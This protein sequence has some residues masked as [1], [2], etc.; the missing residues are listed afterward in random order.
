V[1]VRVHARFPFLCCGFGIIGSA[2]RRGLAVT[3]AANLAV[4]FALDSLLCGQA[5]KH[6]VPEAKL[7]CK[8]TVEQEGRDDDDDA[9]WFGF[10]WLPAGSQQA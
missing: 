6:A 9:A 1:L 7:V 8:A 5:I 2:D 10:E 4:A 3:L